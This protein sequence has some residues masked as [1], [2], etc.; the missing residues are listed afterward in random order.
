[1]SSDTFYQM[2]SDL[3]ALIG[4]LNH[5]ERMHHIATA[6]AILA[7]SVGPCGQAALML[8]DLHC[9]RFLLKDD[10]DKAK[11]EIIRLRVLLGHMPGVSE[12]VEIA[13]KGGLEVRR[14]G[15]D[16]TSEESTVEWKLSRVDILWSVGVHDTPGFNIKGSA[17]IHT[18][19]GFGSTWRFPLK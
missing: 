4:E 17:F 10:L 11:R 5:A 7:P 9:E 13:Y 6:S 16:S 1:M 8:R 3:Q 19:E 12:P 14:V 15:K 2:P 18:P